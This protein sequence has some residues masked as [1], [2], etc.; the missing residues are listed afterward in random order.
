MASKHRADGRGC[1]RRACARWR[2]PSPA[3][4][5]GRCLHQRQRAVARAG[6]RCR[7]CDRSRPAPVRAAGPGAV[8]PPHELLSALRAAAGRGHVGRG[9]RLPPRSQAPARHLRDLEPIDQ[10]GACRIDFPVEMSAIGS[11][12]LKPAATV[13]CAMA[14]AFA[15]W[16]KKELVPSARL[17]YLSGVKT[18]LRG[19]AI[20]A[21]TSGARAPHPSIPRAMP[22]T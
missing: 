12:G 21:A 7:C 5:F 17:R 14:K 6:R 3:C 13:T 2:R 10:G 20:P 22:S 1:R 15:R 4:A 8:Q 18:I 11:V 16:T 9:D 19:R